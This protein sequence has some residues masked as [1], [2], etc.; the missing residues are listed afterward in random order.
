MMTFWQLLQ[1]LVEERQQLV[2]PAVLQGYDSEFKQALNSLI[3]RTE[4]PALRKKFIDML[5]C[6]VREGRDAECDQDGEGGIHVHAGAERR[7]VPACSW[8]T[9]AFTKFLL[10]GA[11]K[12]KAGKGLLAGRLSGQCRRF[13]LGKGMEEMSFREFVLMR[14][15]LAVPTTKISPFPATQ[16]RLKRMATKAV[17][18]PDPFAPTVRP[19]AE[20]VPEKMVRKVRPT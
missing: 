16:A 2:A 17:R 15:K 14:E 13:F 6:N 9:G 5:D 3:G 10:S 4:D 18:A 7:G 11:K 8:M 19:V 12:K 20:V 1:L